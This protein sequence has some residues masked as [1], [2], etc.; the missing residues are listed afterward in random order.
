M[1]RVVDW[2][3][4]LVRLARYTVSAANI[5]SRDPPPVHPN[6]VGA[7]RSRRVRSRQP[8]RSQALVAARLVHDHSASLVKFRGCLFARHLS[9]EKEK[10]GF[11]GPI[12]SAPDSHAGSTS[13]ANQNL[14]AK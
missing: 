9:R 13:D 8:R 6:L 12:V 2:G 10:R 1:T 5:N 14:V 3:Q 11:V 7:P 4:V